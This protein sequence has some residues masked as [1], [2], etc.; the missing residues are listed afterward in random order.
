MKLWGIIS[1]IFADVMY[2]FYLKSKRN[3]EL[4]NTRDL[5]MFIQYLN[6]NVLERKMTL[7]NSVINIKGKISPY[8]DEFIKK[9]RDTSDIMS[10]RK[11]LIDAVESYFYNCD[12]KIRVNIKD[13]LFIL[14]NTDK[15]TS[16]DCYRLTYNECE[17]IFINKKEEIHK[18]IR[19][20]SVL[21][22]GLS[23]MAILVLI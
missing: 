7:F 19:I 5:I 11:S 20:I 23:S 1:V 12:E 14:G 9:F 4:S 15:K 10:V 22:Y 16:T 21:T 18:S 6:V 8:I 13:Y 3:T 2:I 17:K